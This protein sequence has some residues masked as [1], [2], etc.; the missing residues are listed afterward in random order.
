M[1][2]CVRRGGGSAPP[3]G[4]TVY[5]Q[6][7]FGEFAASA[8][9]RPDCFCDCFRMPRGRMLSA[10][11]DPAP[12]PYASVGAGVPDG[13][14]IRTAPDISHHPVGDGVLDVPL[15]DAHPGTIAPV[16]EGLAP[17]EKTDDPAL[18][19][20]VA[21]IVRKSSADTAGPPRTSAPTAGHDVPAFDAPCA[22][23]R[24]RDVEAPSLA[25]T[26]VPVSSQGR[27]A[28]ARCVGYVTGQR[29]FTDPPPFRRGAAFYAFS[30]S[31]LQ[32]RCHSV[33]MPR[34]QLNRRISRIIGV[35]SAGSS[36]HFF[37]RTQAG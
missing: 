17:P 14:Q 1:R 15:S 16:G 31:L 35:Q 36:G 11:A 19:H 29:H 7:M 37:S 8:R 32:T 24:Q 6:K 34:R 5:P 18:L 25:G 12:C 13:P 23:V 9:I 28:A 20:E 26:D 27:L 2:T 30:C 21:Q 33:R 4:A 3:G 22:G 10:P